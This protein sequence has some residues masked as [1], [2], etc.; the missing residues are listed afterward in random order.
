MI[1]TPLD[2]ALSV[3]VER[4]VTIRMGREDWRHVLTP[5]IEAAQDEALAPF[6]EAA[7]A[8]QE[9]KHAPD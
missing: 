5:V 8:I 3:L 1:A 4:F 2:K 6:L 7:E 9:R